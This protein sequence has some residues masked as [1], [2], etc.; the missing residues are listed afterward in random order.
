MAAL[1]ALEV[2]RE[3]GNTVHS[4]GLV[5]SEPNL[6]MK[7]QQSMLAA[8]IILTVSGIIA[9]VAAGNLTAAAP[10]VATASGNAGVEEEGIAGAVVFRVAT[11]AV[12]ALAADKGSGDNDVGGGEAPW[13]ASVR[14]VARELMV[15]ERLHT[16]LA[17]PTLVK[18]LSVAL[19]GV[20]CTST[21]EAAHDAAA[22]FARSPRSQPAQRQQARPEPELVPE[23]AGAAIVLQDTRSLAAPLTS[24]ALTT[25]PCIEDADCIVGEYCSKSPG[26]STGCYSCS[27]I[28]PS[29]CDDISGDCCSATFRAHCT[30]NPAE[31]CEIDAECPRGS[32]CIE[33]HC[34]VNPGGDG[35]ALLAA[36]VRDPATA[37]A[38][39][40]L[41]GWRNASDDP[42]G[43]AFCGENSIPCAW[44]GVSCVG[45]RVGLVGNTAHWYGLGF[46]LSPAVGK[47]TALQIISLVGL[48]L[49]SGTIPSE[50]NELPRMTDFR[51]SVNPR[52]SGTIP[53]A[54][55]ELTGL[56]TLYLNDNS[57]SGTI[58]SEL[59]QLVGIVH[60]LL[61]ANSRLSGTLPAKIAKLSR[62]EQFNLYSNPLLS[63]TMPNECSRLA[64][65]TFLDVHGCIA[66]SGSLPDFLGTTRLILVDASNCSFSGLPTV[67]PPTVNHLYLG[68]NPIVSN[69]TEL[70][71]LLGSLPALHVLDVGFSNSPIVLE[72]NNPLTSFGTR[73]YNPRQC[74]IG[75]PC[76]FTLHMYDSDDKPVH[77]GALISNLT[78]YF[79]GSATPMVD[80]RDGT[81]T[82]SIPAAWISR[83]G[84]FLFHFHHKGIEFW[85]NSTSENRNEP[86][87][88]LL[89]VQFLPRRCPEGSH[90]VPDDQTG[91]VCDT[92]ID[93]FEKVTRANATQ[94]C[95]KSCGI[96]E[97]SHD[98]VACVCTDDYYD[99]NL[100][101]VAI[102]STGEWEPPETISAFASVHAARLEGVKC[103]KCPTQCMRC[104][105]GTAT[106]LEGWRLN[107]S[108]PPG[109]AMQLARGKDGLPQHVFSCPFNPSDCPEVDLSIAHEA[110]IECPNHHVGPLCA[111][112]DAGF[113]RRGS[114]D[115][116]CD[117]CRDISDYIAAT[118]GLS[119]EWFAAL[120]IAAVLV[121]CAA[122]YFF[123]AQLRWLK[124]ETKANIRILIGS[125]QVLSLLPSVLELVF[126]KQPKAALSFIAV[127]VIDLRNILRFECW[128]WTWYDKW[129]ASVF[130]LPLIV[131]LPI[132]MNWLWRCFAARRT[133]ADSRQQVVAEARQTAVGA[134]FF[135][136]MLLYPQISS[137]ILSALRCRRLGE[138]SSYLEA[139]YSV[140]CMNESYLHYRTLALVLVGVVPLGVPLGLLAA[141]MHQFRQ[142][143]KRWIEGEE[144]RGR[145]SARESLLVE[146]DVGGDLQVESLIEY[147]RKR[148]EELFGFCTEDYRAEFFWW[149]P[150][151]LLRKLALSGL[152]Q[153]VHR[154]TAA[155]CFVGSMISF[156][157]FGVQQWLRPY[158]ENG[159]NVLKALVDTQLF[160][161]FLISFIL[162]VLPDINTAEPVH[163]EFYGWLLLSTMIALVACA[164]VLT[165]VQVR[166]RQ[167]FKTRLLLISNGQMGLL[168]RDNTTHWPS[169]GNEPPA[170]G[171]L[172]EPMTRAG[173]ELEPEP[174]P[175]ALSGFPGPRHQHAT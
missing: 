77:M 82:A 84:R 98:G 68:S 156:A 31:C 39:G 75:D 169:E 113:S 120:L 11:A 115:N 124:T 114:S 12:H 53:P 33:G 159:S 6:R 125:A 133:D 64:H 150:V 63:G 96:G 35:A 3:A 23:P 80:D 73:V 57:L 155:Q 36:F 87:L 127:F 147:H 2:Q 69:A 136:T 38:W 91:S 170:A 40:A 22:N 143:H 134:L 16:L 121:V 78:L 153:F 45:G 149:E 15:G 66:L 154:G 128:G 34:D 92:C 60:L 100:Y 7:P 72:R 25:D 67:L 112:C 74:H 85:P 49:F 103:A 17:E 8:P 27:I 126:P 108:T 160:L 55:G 146:L 94:S 26:G 139:D 107:A 61:Q 166:R 171:R 4:P 142:S 165:F 18:A 117:E 151:D 118:F 79:N 10:P 168:T 89:T 104:R 76:A 37:E 163:R 52:L 105:N 110:S 41:R 148:A 123:F 47:L 48:P 54:L 109:M 71:V 1:R 101:G 130:G 13:R 30:T 157:S 58:P 138:S 174:E 83:T 62:M 51:F 65:L 99:T 173:I 19:H 102:C 158:R 161:T 97:S 14:E 93:G 129:L 20:H 135:I 46:E 88:S 145:N 90:T 81:F 44:D 141:L 132:I 86:S 95:K 140:D 175:E 32:H 59:G 164:I 43:A 122:I 28:K 29:T 5:R 42:C 50:V 111:S 106:I 172:A 119:A 21:S 70:S 144:Q 137:A 9:A 152:L 116:E 162:R 131:T 167:R 24:T 56:K